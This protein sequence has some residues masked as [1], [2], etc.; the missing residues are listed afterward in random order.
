MLK[1]EIPE[2]AQAKNLTPSAQEAIASNLHAATVPENSESGG[3]HD[4]VDKKPAA[5]VKS[6]E[7]PFS[8]K[9]AAASKTMAQSR[10]DRKH[11]LARQ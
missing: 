5:S 3:K 4:T 6:I 9:K 10:R 8:P 11:W 7:K 1:I 2:I